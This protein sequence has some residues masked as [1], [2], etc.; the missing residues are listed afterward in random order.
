MNAHWQKGLS[1]QE[2]LKLRRTHECPWAEGTANKGNI[3]RRNVN[4]RSQKGP[5]A[6]RNLEE[7]VNVRSQMGLLR[8]ET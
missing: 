6:G 4:V 3:Q 5:F 7:N 1:M 8:E 2:T